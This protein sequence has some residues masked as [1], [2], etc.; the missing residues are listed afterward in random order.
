MNA[1]LGILFNDK[2]LKKLLGGLKR[3]LLYFGGQLEQKLRQ[4]ISIFRRKFFIF[5][6]HFFVIIFPFLKVSSAFDSLDGCLTDW[7]R[8]PHSSEGLVAST[9]W[10]SAADRG[11]VTAIGVREYVCR[12][13]LSRSSI[14]LPQRHLTYTLAILELL[15]YLLFEKREIVSNFRRSIS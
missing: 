5:L 8:L 13:L 3:R 7:E 4:F 6:F 15:Q 2:R 12:I 9:I 1:P 11:R 14:P 10:R